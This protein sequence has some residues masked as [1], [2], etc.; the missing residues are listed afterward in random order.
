MKP[1]QVL[2]GAVWKPRAVVSHCYVLLLSCL[3]ERAMAL[4]DVECV[5]N[6][7]RRVLQERA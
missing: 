5:E 7:R 2:S 1:A 6:A 3:T 4:G